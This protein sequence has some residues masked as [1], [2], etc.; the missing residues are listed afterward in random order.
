M[1]DK[2]MPADFRL[3]VNVTRNRKTRRLMREMGDRAFYCIVALWCYTAENCP[4]GHLRDMNADDI[5]DVSDWRGDSLVWLDYLLEQHWLDRTTDSYMVHD[6]QEM[7]PWAARDRS[8]QSEANRKNALTRWEKQRKDANSHAIAM[9]TQCKPNAI[10]MPPYPT[11]TQPIPNQILEHDAAGDTPAATT[12]DT[13]DGKSKAKTSQASHIT[14]DRATWRVEGVTDADRA[15]WHDAAPL[16][17]VDQEILKFQNWCMA[18]SDRAPRTRIMAAITRWMNKA[19]EFAARNPNARPKTF[20]FSLPIEDQNP[21]P[22]Q[23]QTWDREQ[24]E[25]E[26]NEMYERMRRHHGANPLEA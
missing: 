6:W 11:H 2:V 18:N 25:R 20:K 26:A 22:K 3:Y 5:A 14:L 12:P 10:A 16:V 23:P 15:R 19:Q 24:V 8:K 7:Q 13:E 21:T 17:N 9:Q 1:S 4:D